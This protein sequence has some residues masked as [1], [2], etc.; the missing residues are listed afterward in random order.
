M[1][2]DLFS[3]IKLTKDF[4]RADNYVNQR[5][6]ILDDSVDAIKSHFE[7]ECKNK[8]FLD[9]KNEVYAALMSQR[10]YSH[11]GKSYC[12]NLFT[13]ELLGV[14]KNS[15]KYV[16][17]LDFSDC[18]DYIIHLLTNCS[19]DNIR[20]IPNYSIISRAFLNNDFTELGDTTWDVLMNKDPILDK[21]LEN[22]Y[23]ELS[24]GC[25]DAVKTDELL[26]R[27]FIFHFHSRL[28]EQVK[29][30][31]AYIMAYL[32]TIDSTF[33]YKSNSYAASIGTSSNYLEDTELLLKNNG[34]PDYKINL[35]IFQRFGYLEKLIEKEE[36]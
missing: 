8:A 27:K 29:V 2:I 17:L 34:S 26:L 32:R 5:K 25:E 36:K 21:Y 31:K 20:N 11:L 28:L 12:D 30:V 19:I 3:N 18:L 22:L 10:Y 33:L 23:W 9:F 13:L 15:K 35:Q 24:D 14:E 4:T 1:V 6:F 7:I 16:I